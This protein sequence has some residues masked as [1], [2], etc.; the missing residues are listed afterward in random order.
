VSTGV[1]LDAAPRRRNRHVDQ[2]CC[3]PPRAVAEPSFPP[4]AT[5]ERGGEEA[6]RADDAVA[7]ASEV[8]RLE[9]RVRELERLLGSRT[10]EIEILKEALDLARAIRPLYRATRAFSRAF[11]S[12]VSANKRSRC[13]RSN[14]TSAARRRSA[15]T[16]RTAVSG[17]AHQDERARR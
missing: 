5:D 1:A 6:V 14:P 2:L 3:P 11:I 7:P 12:S 17:E 4:E 13:S 9:E 8:R 16:A 15:L 10:M